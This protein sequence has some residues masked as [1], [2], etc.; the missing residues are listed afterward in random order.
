M[1]EKALRESFQE[2]A[3]Q[4]RLSF[5]WPLPPEPCRIFHKMVPQGR[6]WGLCPPPGW[7]NVRNLDCRRPGHD[8]RTVVGATR[9]VAPEL[10]AEDLLATGEA[11]IGIGA[12]AIAL[13]FTVV[14]KNSIA[15]V[16]TQTCEAAR[17]CV[18][19]VAPRKHL[20]FRKYDFL[21]AKSKPLFRGAPRPGEGKC[22]LYGEKYLRGLA[23]GSNAC[24]RTSY[25]NTLLPK[26]RFKQLADVL[27]IY[28]DES[29]PPS[30][31]HPPPS[32]PSPP[33]SPLPPP[34]PPSSPPPPPA[35]CCQDP[36]PE[37]GRA[38]KCLRR[39]RKAQCTAIHNKFCPVAC[40]FCQICEGHPQYEQYSRL[41]LRMMVNRT[42][43]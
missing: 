25:F 14:K 37:P 20:V 9:D 27:Q 21:M 15:W 38:M 39:G 32:P 23:S 5:S 30:P 26:R 34:S 33:P 28:R 17:G 16:C 13:N 40:G 19:V 43:V 3:Q 11:Q 7:K 1:S 41:A 6:I 18:F 4:L 24:Q 31:P 10:L 35:P 29:P 36:S 2:L 12:A 8:H 42:A 22:L